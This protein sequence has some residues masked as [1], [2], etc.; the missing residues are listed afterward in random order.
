MAKPLQRFLEL[1]NN[2][3]CKSKSKVVKR[4]T[5]HPTRDKNQEYHIPGGLSEISAHLE[6]LKLA[7]EVFAIELISLAIKKKQIDNGR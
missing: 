5:F 7:R 2:S 6:D 1:L 3:Y 4:E